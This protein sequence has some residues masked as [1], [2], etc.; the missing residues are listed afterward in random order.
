M[1][2]TGLWGGVWR[3]SSRL[4]AIS[5]F[6]LYQSVAVAS[7]FANMHVYNLCSGSIYIQSELMD[8]NWHEVMNWGWKAIDN[9]L[10][11]PGKT[12]TISISSDRNGTNKTTATINFTCKSGVHDYWCVSPEAKLTSLSNNLYTVSLTTLTTDTM[13]GTVSFAVSKNPSDHTCSAS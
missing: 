8:S 3:C 10:I 5:V 1:R 4:M 9:I 12:Y 2:I 11:G 6:M 13:K 7:P